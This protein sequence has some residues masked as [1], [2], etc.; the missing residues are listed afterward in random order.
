MRQ[1]L[2]GKNPK[3]LDWLHK[4]NKGDNHGNWKGDSVKSGAL[5]DWVRRWKGKPQTCLHCKASK[6]E[7]RLTWANVD[8]K[9]RRNVDDFISLCYK[10]H[11]MYDIK[12]NNYPTKSRFH[13]GHEMCSDTKKKISES[14]KRVRTTKVVP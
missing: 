14:M 9:Y 13:K 3:N 10:C 1:S 7:K 12:N 5:H 4:F 8:H 11:Q 6:E 2:R